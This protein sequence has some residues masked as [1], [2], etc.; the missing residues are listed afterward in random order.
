[1]GVRSRHAA[2]VV[3]CALGVLGTTGV[4][5]AHAKSSPTAQT[6]AP[7][8]VAAAS[9]VLH[10]MVDTGGQKTRYVADRCDGTLTRV[11]LG[12]VSVRDLRRQ[13]TVVVRAG[14]SYLARRAG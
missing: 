7:T 6:Q 14:H 2:A 10:G 11:T 3:A 4:A 1:V 9:A 12:G 13:P 8:A 5:F